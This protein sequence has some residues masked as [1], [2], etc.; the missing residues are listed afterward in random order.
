M[1]PFFSHSSWSGGGMI[2]IIVWSLILKGYALWYASRR[3]EKGWFIA[4]LILNTVGIIEVIYLLAVVRI[5]DVS[6]TSEA[7]KKIGKSVRRVSKK[8]TRT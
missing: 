2:F 4:L 1:M 6:P 8:I 3:N 5:F 7:P